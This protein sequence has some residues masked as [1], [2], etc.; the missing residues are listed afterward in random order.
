MA[1]YSGF[2]HKKWW[3]SIA[4]L[5]YQRVSQIH[6]PIIFPIRMMGKAWWSRRGFQL[7]F[8]PLPVVKPDAL[9]VT[10]TLTNK[11][12]VTS[13][14][15]GPNS[16]T[17]TKHQLYNI[18]PQIILCSIIIWC[19]YIYILIYINIY[20]Y[21][22]YIYIY[23]CIYVHIDSEFD[24]RNKEVILWKNW[25]TIHKFVVTRSAVPWIKA[26]CWKLAWWA[27]TMKSMKYINCGSY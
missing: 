10:R 1:I 25:S 24:C 3:F 16:T 14:L 17:T 13:W 22:K 7:Q 26:S 21:I 19:I 12:G 5:V 9:L 2:T 8:P 20:I 18:L 11:P 27:P 15:W 23:Y 6:G 4:M